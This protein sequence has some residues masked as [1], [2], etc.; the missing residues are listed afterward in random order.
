M[1]TSIGDRFLILLFILCLLAT[2]IRVWSLQAGGRGELS[3]FSVLLEWRDVDA[4]TA[5]C[6]SE[7]EALYTAAGEYYGV[8]EGLELLPAQWEVVQNGEVLR[9]SLPLE[10]RCN[11]RLRVRVQ[12]REENGAFLRG[13][14]QALAMGERIKLYSERCEI[15]V[16][17]LHFGS[18]T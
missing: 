4:R 8:V 14:F 18:E 10:E 7:G 1:R 16:L 9:L 5:A 15:A 13:G 3:E 11:V 12:G 17:I 6:L 2:G